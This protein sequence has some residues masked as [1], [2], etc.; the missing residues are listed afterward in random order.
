MQLFYFD[1]FGKV[2]IESSILRS[3]AV[4]FGSPSG[5]SY[6]DQA[7]HSRIGT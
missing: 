1:G 5:Q 2:M 3:L 6:K 4:L 7:I